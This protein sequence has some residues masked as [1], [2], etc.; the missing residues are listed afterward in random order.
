MGMAHVA[1]SSNAPRSRID[2]RSSLSVL[3]IGERRLAPVHVIQQGFVDRPVEGRGLVA[4]E[5]LLPARVRPLREILAAFG[6]PL[7]DAVVVGDGRAVERR[8]EVGLGVRAAEEVLAGA[9]L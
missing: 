8:L 2:T 6:F 9:D 3:G 5:L 4:R 7:L 1:S